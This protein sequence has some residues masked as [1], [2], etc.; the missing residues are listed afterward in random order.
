MV[1]GR[2]YF[3]SEKKTNPRFAKAVSLKLLVFQLSLPTLP[4]LTR[5]VRGA[6]GV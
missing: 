1:S 4:E 3:S 6:R 5:R 2:P